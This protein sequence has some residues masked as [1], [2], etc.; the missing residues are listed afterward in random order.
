MSTALL[1]T[2][3]TYDELNEMLRLN[4]GFRVL[5]CPVCTLPCVKERKSAKN[6]EK[7]KEGASWIHHQSKVLAEDRI[8]E[9]LCF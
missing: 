8:K 9:V 2:Q 7:W 3:M 5:C 1:P 4:K 6:E